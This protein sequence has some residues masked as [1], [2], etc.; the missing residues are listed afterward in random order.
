MDVSPFLRTERLLI[1]PLALTD[2]EFIFELVNTEGWIRFIGNR[3]ISSQD[4]ARAYIQK[5]LENENVSYWV[6]QRKEPLDAIGI[7]TYIKRDYLE[8]HDIGFA[9]LPNASK[10]GYAFEATQAVLHKLIQERNP[11]QVLATTIPDNERSIKLLQKIGF[12]FEKEM[13]V[14]NTKLHVYG[15]S[16]DKLKT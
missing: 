7:I 6:V 5:V 3:N 10:N 15:T 13:N 8:H 4:E 2:D 11:V 14:E 9:F 1:K 16:A 12:A